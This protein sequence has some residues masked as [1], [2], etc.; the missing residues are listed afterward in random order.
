MRDLLRIGLMWGVSLINLPRDDCWLQP[1]DAAVS[2]A[3]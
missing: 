2:S 3:A 1:I